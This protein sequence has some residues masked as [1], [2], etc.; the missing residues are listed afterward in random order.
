[1]RGSRVCQETETRMQGR[2]R[3]W[4]P[5]S[6]KPQPFLMSPG[7]AAHTGSLMAWSFRSSAREVEV[8]HP[9]ASH[10]PASPRGKAEDW[11]AEAVGPDRA[12]GL[13]SLQGSEV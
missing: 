11:P 12:T 8:W 2:C 5:F 4:P 13:H 10:S 3:D 6:Q 9:W 7:F 1:M